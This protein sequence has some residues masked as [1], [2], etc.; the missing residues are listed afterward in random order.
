MQKLKRWVLISLIISV[1][2]LLPMSAVAETT[3][4]QIDF[5][6]SAIDASN[7]FTVTMTIRN[8]TFNAMQFVLRYDVTKF[9]PIDAS[10]KMATSNFSQF[11]VINSNLTESF[12]SLDMKI[13]KELGLI[14]FTQYITPGNSFSYQAETIVNSANI[15]SSPLQFFVFH[16][17]LL[18]LNNPLL[19]LAKQE[20]NK[21]YREYLPNGGGLAN[22]GIQ[23]SSTI[24]IDLTKLQGQIIVDEYV[25]PLPLPIIPPTPPLEPPVDE[26]IPKRPQTA[27]ERLKNTLVMQIGNY[28][29]AEDGALCHIYPSEKDVVPYIRD[30]RTFVPIRF[31]AEKLG[32]SVNWDEV[33]R[34]VTF[35]KGEEILKLT[36]GEHRYEKNGKYFSIDTAAEIQWNRTMVP[37]RFVAEALGYAVEWNSSQSMVF[38]TDTTLPWL[39]EDS[40]EEQATNDVAFIISPL[41]RDFV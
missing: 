19:E 35:T 32:M 14:D 1:V 25:N 38:I 3:S 10:T 16:F 4:A 2:F 36:I 17:K 41:L 22:A 37:V 29:A 23:L 15:G 28:A 6:A 21:N 5:V 27:K 33:A 24:N 11:A 18:D 40:V 30:N 31:I 12:S 26:T 9:L 34:T 20:A 13:D 39:L 8:A 7:N